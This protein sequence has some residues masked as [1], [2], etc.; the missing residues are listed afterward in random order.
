M[1]GYHQ[2]MDIQQCDVFLGAEKHSTGE[3]MGVA[4]E[5]PIA[6][7]MVDPGLEQKLLVLWNCFP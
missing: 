4:Y 5:F 7:T 2:V 3:L 1:L 6:F